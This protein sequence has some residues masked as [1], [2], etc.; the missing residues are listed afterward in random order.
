[1][2]QTY[3]FCSFLGGF[4]CCFSSRDICRFCHAQ[5]SDLLS[6]I[7]DYDGDRMHSYWSK[8][9]YDGIC[10]RI[11]EDE[12]SIE[13]QGSTDVLDLEADV[14]VTDGGEQQE[15]SDVEEES[16]SGQVPDE[17]F[18]ASDDPDS[19]GFD[20]EEVLELA[21]NNHGLRYRCVF[22]QLQSFHATLS[23]PPDSMHDALEGVAAQDLNAG[24]KILSLRKWFSLEEYNKKLKGLGFPSYESAD[25]PEAV[26]KKSRKL[27]GKACSIW[28][29][30]RNFPLVVKG[31]LHDDDSLKSD[32]EVLLWILKLI[33]IVNRISA[34][35]FRSHEID[36]LETEIVEYLDIRKDIYDQYPD[37]VGTPKPKVRFHL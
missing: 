4:S 22:N 16:Y 14:L 3:K 26:N 19:D 29:H 13:E 30:V 8:E 28:V 2:D 9:Q 31:F 1:M 32:D 6:H 36:A 5:H 25:I 33:D 7:H 27:S 20:E 37:S 23:F 18:D 35:E 21:A 17:D 10:D 34:T 24:I 15:E 12:D 11:E